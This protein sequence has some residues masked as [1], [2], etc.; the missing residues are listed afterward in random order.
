M[1]TSVEPV[2]ELDILA[3]LMEPEILADPYPFY[4]WIRE[5]APVHANPT[6]GVYLISRNSDVRDVYQSPKL[7]VDTSAL[8]AKHPHWN[9]SG[10]LRL[11][12][13]SFTT[14]DP[15]DH[16][17]VRRVVSRHFTLRR[18]RLL[19]EA[20]A[21]HCDRLLTTLAAKL[22]DG[23]M[24]DLHHEL[25]DPVGINLAGDIIGVPES[26]RAELSRLIVRV[27]ASVHPAADK[28]VL[29]AG[30]E[31]SDQ[32]QEYFAVLAAERRRTPT[33]DLISALLCDVVEGDSK[34]EQGIT[35]DEFLQLLWGLWVASF[36]STVAAMEFGVLAMLDFPEQ[37][38]WLDGG[39]EA[40]NAFVSESLRYN[41]PVIVEGLPRTALEDLTISGVTIP[42]GAD[43]R[44]MHGPANRDPA[45]FPDPDRFDPSRN[46]ARMVT[47]GYG[48]HHCL[49][50][51]LARME[52]AVVLSRVRREL[53]GLAMH[54]PPELRPSMSL[55]TIER[56]PVELRNR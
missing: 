49:G 10:S 19:E 4:E 29:A 17:R 24:A 42:A 16:T 46:T 31:A 48:T 53:P 27:L 6:G 13:Q 55:R 9:E 35:R 26:D 22:A 25:T 20:A 37:A 33:D 40:I 12:M 36:E 45:A 21:R 23:Q 41:P 30:D 47:F 2:E 8:A 28:A 32:V 43:V 14:A 7:R 54:G 39:A 15:A 11:L 51:N 44:P 3:R 52:C 38:H 34:P 50:N 56:F 1:T 18:T 5:N